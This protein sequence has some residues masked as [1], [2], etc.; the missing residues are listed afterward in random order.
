MHNWAYQRGRERCKSICLYIK[1]FYFFTICVNEILHEISRYWDSAVISELFPHHYVIVTA[2]LVLQGYA[3]E[4]ESFTL[5]FLGMY[6]IKIKLMDGLCRDKRRGFLYI[7]LSL[8]C[9]FR[10]CHIV[11]TRVE[12]RARFRYFVSHYRVFLIHVYVCLY[13]SV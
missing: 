8:V 1:N 5:F 12:L 3:L 9:E 10:L 11:L 6:L 4:I 13:V 2:S 7:F